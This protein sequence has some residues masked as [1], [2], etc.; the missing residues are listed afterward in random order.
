[1]LGWLLG[2]CLL[3]RICASFISKTF[4]SYPLFSLSLSIFSSLKT[5]R[6]ILFGLDDFFLWLPWVLEIKS[7]IG[8][9]EF[10]DYVNCLFWVFD[11]K[12]RISDDSFKNGICCKLDPSGKST[13]LLI[14][15]CVKESFILNH[16]F[17]LSF[18]LPGCSFRIAS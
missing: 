14:F 4:Y 12:F 15:C 18:K 8:E 6:V 10:L 3:L 2:L 13:K 7:D 17:L 16:P 1:M 11:R 5:G 9:V